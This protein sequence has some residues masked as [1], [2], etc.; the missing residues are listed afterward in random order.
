MS[1]Y[2]FDSIDPY[3]ELGRSIYS[4]QIYLNVGYPAYWMS[5]ATL[6]PIA[7]EAQPLSAEDTTK[8]VAA[9]TTAEQRATLDETGTVD[10][11][12]DSS[13]GKH[14]A[15]LYKQEAGYLLIF[16]SLM[17]DCYLKQG[18]D[19]NCSDIHLPTACPPSWRRHGSLQ[20]MWEGA[21][22]F[23]KEDTNEL[24]NS[25]LTEHEWERLTTCCDLDCP[26]IYEF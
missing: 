7:E 10:F 17:A 13:A 1:T 4:P 15:Y 12:I 25:F 16:I 6:A 21:P 3:L 5:H 20:P 22:S 23:T 9:C 26:P 14:H 11:I 19:C 2:I 24:A 8:L 18:V